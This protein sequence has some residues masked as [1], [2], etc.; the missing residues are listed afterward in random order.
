MVDGLS[1]GAAKS[2]YALRRTAIASCFIPGDDLRV[3]FQDFDGYVR[4]VRYQYGV[5]YLGG[6]K[7]SIIES[8]DDVKYHGPL[9][10]VASQ[11]P[12]QQVIVPFPSRTIR[13]GNLI[14]LD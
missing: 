3:Y 14:S 9:A 1:A 12:S 4:E 11:D 2:V 10:V 6:N 13:V 5:G 8:A 7:N